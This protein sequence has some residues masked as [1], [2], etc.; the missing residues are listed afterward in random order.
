MDKYKPI[1]G[2]AAG[3]PYVALPPAGDRTKRAP[4]VVAWH[5]MDPPRTEA[6]LA[7]AL[8]LAEVQA[9]RVYLG[10]PMFG[11]RSPA[12][13]FDEVLRLSAE[14]FVLKVFAPVVEQAAAEAPAAIEALRAEL[15]IEDGPIGLVGGSMGSAVA[16]LLL[17]EGKLP[18]T[19]AALIS[20]VVQLE[21]VMTGHSHHD[22]ATYAWTEASRVVAARFD[23]V[24]RATEV[25]RRNP[26]PA[27]LLVTGA[28][29]VAA[30]REPATAFRDALL[31]FYADPDRISVVSVP[32]MAHALADS[33]GIEPAPQTASAQRVDA[34]VTDWF[35]RYLGR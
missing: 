18:V 10:L 25:A 3:V 11:A 31:G 34:V 14:D 29:D 26:Q 4:L 21:P 28:D 22:S 12:G 15:P 5:L 23:F 19:A 17:S 16:L 7:S 8:P 9:W 6:A 13:G 1:T 30:F 35:R 2:V 33:P 20:P 24:A 32:E 27:V